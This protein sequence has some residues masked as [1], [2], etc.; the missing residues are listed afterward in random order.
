MAEAFSPVHKDAVSRGFS[1]VYNTFGMKLLLFRFSP[2]W[3]CNI[4]HV[5]SCSL[6]E[7]QRGHISLPCC[8][9]SQNRLKIKAFETSITQLSLTEI[10]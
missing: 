1:G 7:T 5:A 8:P 4:A 10:G 3:Q 9:F 6:L 2:V